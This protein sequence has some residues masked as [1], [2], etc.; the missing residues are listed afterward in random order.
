MDLFADAE[1]AVFRFIPQGIW[2]SPWPVLVSISARARS[3]SIRLRD[4]E[5]TRSTANA[6]Y[7]QEEHDLR[8]ALSSTMLLYLGRRTFVW[9]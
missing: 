2:R 3:L 4:G 7:A 6:S 8:S 9:F 1:P 5:T